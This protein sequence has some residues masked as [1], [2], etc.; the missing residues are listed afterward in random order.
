MASST[1]NNGAT[2][3]NLNVLDTITADNTGGAEIIELVDVA[4]ALFPSTNATQT[5]TIDAAFWTGNLKLTFA[6]STAGTYFTLTGST[7]NAGHHFFAVTLTD[8]SG[9]QTGSTSGPLAVTA[10]TASLFISQVAIAASAIGGGSGLSSTSLLDALD[11]TGGSGKNVFQATTNGQIANIFTYSTATDSFNGTGSQWDVIN[12]FNVSVDKLDFRQLVNDTAY[13]GVKT[14]FNAGL[15]EFIWLGQEPANTT[16]LGAAG[17][18]AVWYT[19]DGSGGSFVYADTNGD[20]V[21]DLKV[22]VAGVP[23]LT[24]DNFFGVDPP[25]AFTVTINPIEPSQS[26]QWLINAAD[27]SAGVTVTGT[28][29]HFT[30][31]ANLTVN[32]NGHNYTATV[33]ANGTWSA[34]I[35]LSDLSHAALPDGTY[36]LSATVKVGAATLASASHSITVDETA[37]T[38]TI[39]STI[40]TN[41]GL[42][43]TISSGGLTK[44]NTL[45]LSGT[46]SDAN[47][48]ASVQVYD[49]ATLLGSATVSAGAWTFTTAALIDGSHSF[50]AKATDNAGNTFTTATPVTATVDTTAP[51]ETISS[52]IGTNTG[53]TTTITS[54]GLTKDN[55]LA[56]SGTV[57]DANG[58]ASVHVFDGA[59]DLGAATVVAGNWSFTT[60]ALI[61]GSHSFT[62]K[63][64]DNAGN[65]FTTA[66]PVTATVDT[67]A[68]TETISSTIGT[69]T[70]ATTTITSGG[71]TKD[72]TLA[73][74]GTVSDA[75]GVASV[76]VFDGATD[77]GA[78]TV[79]AGNWSFTTA[80][81]IDGSHSFTAK[82]TDTPPTPRPAPVTSI[83]D[84]TA[85]SPADLAVVINDGDGYID[86]A[87]KSA[88]NYTVSGVDAD[89]TATVTFTSS[90]G[91]TP[92]VVGSLGNGAT[93]VDL[94]GLADGTITATI[95]ATDTATNTAS[96]TGDTSIK[97]ITADSPADL[98]VVINDGDGYIDN[99]EKSAVNYTVSGVD[100][101]ATA[102]VTFTSSGGG[103]PVVVGSLGNGATTVDLS[104][105]AD[106]T[107]TATISATDTATNT[108]SGTA[109]HQVIRWRRRRRPLMQWRRTTSSTLPNVM[110]R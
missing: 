41:T 51:T 100:A 6:G 84:I 61:D 29:T 8:Q 69:N 101:D 16:N 88:V 7:D 31:S 104:G 99:A 103:T 54:G 45:A 73:L 32:L 25:A 58:V 59:T 68:P 35:L 28:V 43:T 83:T 2:V 17:A 26:N 38:E 109:Q 1:S 81:L 30:P 63:A 71:L 76:H 57:S 106:G 39:S 102:T 5:Q 60:A 22:N 52:T 72:N 66:T 93:T 55:T 53:A 10:T 47:G 75:N 65:T 34:V 19:T 98:A 82:A 21:A 56:L 62:A 15:A 13:A 37:P 107:I 108:A 96:G 42:T 94:S 64:T 92:V 89:A 24:P 70:G 23:T 18:F 97:D 78:A 12:S 46:V 77:L 74:S 40:G 67:T 11:I 50:T 105:L 90:G 87:E 86:N 85:D 14:A 49:G 9:N 91:G 3:D 110:P 79:V 95:S 80:A 33:A 48:V 44:D 4:I 27:A 20:G 36:T